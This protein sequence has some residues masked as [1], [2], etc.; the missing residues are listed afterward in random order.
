VFANKLFIMHIFGIFMYCNEFRSFG[1]NH[2]SI[3][4]ASSN[5]SELEVL[6]DVE[7]T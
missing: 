5:F 6:F 2:S 3:E 4:Q 1:S 7:L